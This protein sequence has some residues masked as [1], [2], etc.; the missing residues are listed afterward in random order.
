MM[1]LMAAPIMELHKKFQREIYGV[2]ENS[3]K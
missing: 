1:P 3:K 2:Y